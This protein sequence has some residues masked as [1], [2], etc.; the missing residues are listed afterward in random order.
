[1]IN[2]SPWKWN[3]FLFP[4]RFLDGRTGSGRYD[5]SCRPE[6]EGETSTIFLLA[7]IFILRQSKR[8]SP[9]LTPEEPSVA[10]TQLE[11]EHNSPVEDNEDTKV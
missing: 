7:E 3:I 10:Q 2:R 9:M 5:Q 8:D 6:T 11:V 1:M 4:T